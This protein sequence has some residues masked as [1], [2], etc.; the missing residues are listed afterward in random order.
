[1]PIQNYCNDCSHRKIPESIK[2]KFNTHVKMM[3]DECPMKDPKVVGCLIKFTTVDWKA[4]AKWLDD[5]NLIDEN[6]RKNLD[7]LFG[8]KNAKG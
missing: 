3:Y 8:N 5:H 1:M 4:F 6:E 2:Q 7:V